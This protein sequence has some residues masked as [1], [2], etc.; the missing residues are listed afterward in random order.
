ML[1]IR[2]ET[3]TDIL[4]IRTI[5]QRASETPAE[6]SLVDALRARRAGILSLVAEID[7]TATGHIFFS[8]VTIQGPPGVFEAAGLAPMAVLPE[9]Q[10]CSFPT[11]I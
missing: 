2:P 3:E 6:A 7:G 1:T 4:A 10:H 9:F 8:A 5:N 11:R